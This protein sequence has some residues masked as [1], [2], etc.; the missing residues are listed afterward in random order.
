M[1]NGRL[2]PRERPQE[3]HVGHVRLVLGLGVLGLHLLQVPHLVIV[4]G[5]LGRD[6]EAAQERPVHLHPSAKACFPAN[7]FSGSRLKGPHRQHEVSR[8]ILAMARHLHEIR[9]LGPGGK[10]HGCIGLQELLQPQ[11]TT[12][13]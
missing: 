3:H 2:S 12:A 5:I 8:T 7:L 13:H 11:G 4:A 9:S 1:Q 6:V 10:V